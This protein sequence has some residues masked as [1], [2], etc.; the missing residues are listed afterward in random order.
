MRI[1]CLAEDVALWSKWDILSAYTSKG[2]LLSGISGAFFFVSKLCTVS[3]WGRL[4]P[5]QCLVG[6]T[7][8]ASPHVAFRLNTLIRDRF[9]FRK[10][11][12]VSIYPELMKHLTLN[13]RY[14]RTPWPP[15]H[16]WVTYWISLAASSDGLLIGD[17]NFCHIVA[18]YSGEFGYYP[19][20]AARRAFLCRN[21]NL[22]RFSMV[23]NRSVRTKSLIRSPGNI[24]PRITQERYRLDNRPPIEGF[25]A[26]TRP[27]DD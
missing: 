25:Y 20:G 4:F 22:R 1:S 3:G 5:L 6:N 23:G 7:F 26:Y 15:S 9:S 19:N 13:L 14:F 18:S 27:I 8:L 17:P 24:Y 16:W 11:D 10:W 12:G 2:F 21:I